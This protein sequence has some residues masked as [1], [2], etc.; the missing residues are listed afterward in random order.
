MENCSP[1]P[2]QLWRGLR[3]P[4]RIW[5]IGH[6]S[7]TKPLVPSHSLWMNEQKSKW[8]FYCRSAAGAYHEM[9]V[10]PY[11]YKRLI[12]GEWVLTLDIVWI[13]FQYVTQSVPWEM[14]WGGRWWHRMLSISPEWT[15]SDLAGKI[16]SCLMGSWVT[17][18]PRVYLP[19]PR[20]SSRIKAR[21]RAS[22]TN[23]NDSPT[24]SVTCCMKTHS[25]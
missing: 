9:G 24:P 16:P 19:I 7:T 11:F 20:K 17:P 15:E 23:L 18:H 25:L 2:S 4:W 8:W 12:H 6:L 3:S 5:G 14:P 1:H 22:S 13:G 21:W 10:S